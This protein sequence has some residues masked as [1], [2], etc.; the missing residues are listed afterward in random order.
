MVAHKPLHFYLRKPTGFTDKNAVA[1]VA[2]ADNSIDKSTHSTV[3]PEEI[4]I[5][6][7]HPHDGLVSK[8]RVVP[9]HRRIRFS[10]TM[11][12]RCMPSLD[13][14]TVEELQ[15]TWYQRPE[16]KAIKQDNIRTVRKFAR[17]ELSSNSDSMSI[18]QDDCMRGL[19]QRTSKGFR[20]RQD[21]KQAGHCAVLD[22]QDELG[23]SYGFH[24][25]SVD[26]DACMYEELIAER[27]ALVS[28]K[29]AEAAR[30]AAIRDQ[31]AAALM[32]VC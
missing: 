25:N 20:Q 24:S 32:A 5:T 4:D 9:P 31:Q 11:T 13:D 21:N 23:G 6:K 3:S 15:N 30:E 19:E 2:H 16:I 12:V 22:M 1:G 29:C 27:Y 10:E 7:A 8:A 17:G 26:G 14:Y 28:G 18:D